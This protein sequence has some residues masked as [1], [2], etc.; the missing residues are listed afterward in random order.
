MKKTIFAG[1]AGVF[2][3]AACTKPQT[4]INKLD[5]SWDITSFTY[6][7]VTA[8]TA[9]DV[10]GTVSGTF[11][12]TK[13][14]AKKEDSG[15]I[16]GLMTMTQSFGGFTYS[17]TDTIDGTFSLDEDCNYLYTVDGDNDKDTMD[18]AELSKK[19]LTLERTESYPGEDTYK[20]T[21]KFEKQ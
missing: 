5:G 4:C 6:Y 10:G 7:N 8:D 13:Y 14:K 1:I 9:V 2:A 21:F 15:D 19:E 16:F 17:E 20:M 11:E 3:L 18:I 12:F